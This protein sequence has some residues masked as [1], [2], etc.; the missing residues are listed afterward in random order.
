MMLGSK[1]T[2]PT[3]NDVNCSVVSQ[4]PQFFKHSKSADL[5][6]KSLLSH[7][8]RVKR[9]KPYSCKHEWH[10]DLLTLVSDYYYSTESVSL[11]IIFCNEVKHEV[12]RGVEFVLF[13]MYYNR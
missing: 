8:W 3:T 9:S 11:Q 2:L 13:I 12:K 4:L 10:F 1:G 6:R 5:L 7:V